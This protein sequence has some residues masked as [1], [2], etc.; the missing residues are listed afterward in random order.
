[1]PRSLSPDALRRLGPIESQSLFR[2]N[3]I[4]LWP[5]KIGPCR[6][7]NCLFPQ[8]SSRGDLLSTKI[9][10]LLLIPVQRGRH[11]APPLDAYTACLKKGSSQCRAQVNAGSL[12]P[13][14]PKAFSMA[15]RNLLEDGKVN[16]PNRATGMPS[17][18]TKIF[19]K[20]H[21]TFP[22]V[23]ESSPTSVS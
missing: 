18:P 23:G 6:G 1:M 8:A 11:A 7:I 16:D 21:F 15:L 12:H 14:S 10:F 19:V 13:C 5:P 17:R 9:F 2:S 20:F 22:L 4:S 3:S